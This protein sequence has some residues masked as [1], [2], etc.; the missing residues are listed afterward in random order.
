ME[1]RMYKN[2]AQNYSARCKNMKI[3]WNYIIS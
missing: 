3:D 2:T 1:E